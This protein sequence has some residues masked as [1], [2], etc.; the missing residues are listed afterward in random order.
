MSAELS[1]DEIIAAMDPW[2][3][4]CA[5]GAENGSIGRRMGFDMW[6]RLSR[7]NWMPEV[8]MKTGASELIIEATMREFVRQNRER[9]FRDVYQRPICPI[10]P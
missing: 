3:L 6:L 5:V 1:A 7:K 8:C 2:M 4:A 9:H 10:S